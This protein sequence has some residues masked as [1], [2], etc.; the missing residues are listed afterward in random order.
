MVQKGLLPR[1]PKIASNRNRNW[2]GIGECKTCSFQS[3]C[4]QLHLFMHFGILVERERERE[5]TFFVASWNKNWKNHWKCCLLFHKY[6]PW[7]EITNT[8]S[9][10]IR[11]DCSLPSIE[12]FWERHCLTANC[13]WIR[14]P[15]SNTGFNV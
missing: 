1:W 6:L 8:V 14:I 4:C 5:R 3:M 9:Y 10:I 2:I 12:S 11:G 7:I 15:M 13:P